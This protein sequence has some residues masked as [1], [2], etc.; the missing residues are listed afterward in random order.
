MNENP[1]INKVAI[2]AVGYNRPDAMARLLHSVEN[3]EYGNDS[4]DLIISIDKGE[5]RDEIEKVAQRIDWKHGKKIIK[6][7]EERMGL[8]KHILSC[9]DMTA[10][11][12]AVVVLEDDLSVSRAFYTYVKAAIVQYNGD[13]RIAG[14]SLYSYQMLPY[15]SR[16]FI[17]DQNGYDA[18]LMQVA[19]SWG[20][21]W[22]RKMWE[23]FKAWYT[24]NNGIIPNDG[25]IPEAVVNW[26]D[27]SWLKYYDR[28]VAECGKYFAMP[29]VALATDHT[30]IGEHAKADSTMFEV[31]LL[32]GLKEFR[33]PKFEEAVRY[34]AFFERQDIDFANIMQVDGNVL[35]DLNGLKKCGGEYTYILSSA[36][37]P[38]KVVKQYGL[39]LRPIEENIVQE[40]P[41][42]SL[43]LYDTQIAEKPKKTSSI[44]LDRYDLYD[45]EW[46]QALRF[47]IWKMLQMVKKLF[48]TEN[49]H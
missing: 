34:D 3:A 2:V 42:E 16:R 32:N 48:F 33:F 28:Y 13:A 47:S 17:P 44:A 37:L 27:K 14:I 35:V 18:Y 19:M 31:P 6:K 49:K 11:Y 12:E 29:Y 10:D 45:A 41:G 22:T 24:T 43:F 46:R 7:H 15:S 30:E 20:Q 36:T 23:D 4:V 39:V 9:G 8:K 26:G 5:R 40:V 21:C 1:K 25:I 38:Y